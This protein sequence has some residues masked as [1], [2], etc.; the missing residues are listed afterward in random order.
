VCQKYRTPGE[1]GRL[2]S[3]LHAPAEKMCGNRTC[4]EGRPDGRLENP[5]SRT[6]SQYPPFHDIARSLTRGISE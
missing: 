1:E 4:R 6:M 3:S 2:G 5:S